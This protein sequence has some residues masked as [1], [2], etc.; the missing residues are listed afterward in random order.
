VQDQHF[1]VAVFE[2]TGEAL[3]GAEA[4]SARV[5][6]AVAVPFMMRPAH[7]APVFWAMMAV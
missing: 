5:A 3:A 7:K 1:E 6:F 4:L 2:E